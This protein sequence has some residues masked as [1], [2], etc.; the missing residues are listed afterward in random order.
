MKPIRKTP[1][2][3]FDIFAKDYNK[4]I[5][6]VCNYDST[7]DVFCNSIQKEDAFIVD[8]ACGPGNISSYLLKKRPH[9][10]VLGVDLAPKMAAIAELN[11]P[12]AIFKVM[13]CRV[14]FPHVQ[15]VDGIV[16]G[17]GLPY[18][19]KEDAVKLIADAAGSLNDDGVLYI[20]TMENDYSNSKIEVSSSGEYE[21]Q[22][23]YHE[24]AYLK[25]AMI[26]SG[27][28]VKLEERLKTVDKKGNDV[29]DLIL[30]GVR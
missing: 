6:T 13:D 8:L 5:K 26:D 15:N 2:E 12:Q 27:L 25:K 23:Y 14:V 24:A 1:Q 10:N 19:N 4:W 21:T 7:L 3:I 9:F 16:C 22:M 17:F 29:V 30:I 20:S 28:Q 18:L 11:N